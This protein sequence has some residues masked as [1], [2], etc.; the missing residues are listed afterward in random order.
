MARPYTTS[1]AVLAAARANG[2]LGGRPRADFGPAAIKR[3]RDDARLLGRSEV[4]ASVEF[5]LWVRDDTSVDLEKRLSCARELLDRYGDPK[6]AVT[7]SVALDVDDVKTLEFVNFKP[8]DGWNGT[9]AE[10][11]TPGADAG[12]NGNGNGDGSGLPH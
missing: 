4:L 7:I 11:E 6:Q 9:R 10:A 2:K 3:A 8:P 12:G 1:L 5:L